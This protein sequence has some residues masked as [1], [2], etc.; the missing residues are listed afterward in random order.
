MDKNYLDFF[1]NSIAKLRTENLYRQFT[2]ISR[3]KG[4]F[5]YAINNLNNHKITLW[6]SNDY[7]A[8]GQNEKA[9]K[10]ANQA[11]S[12]FGLG[13]GGTRNIS[14]NNEL[15]VKLEKEIAELYGKPSALCFVSGYV[16]NDATI[17]TLAKIIPNLVIFSDEKNHASIISGIR[18][19]KLEKHIFRHNDTND[20]E[21]LLKQFPKESP[22]IIIFESVYSMDGDFGEIA[23]IVQLAKKYNALTYCD[24]VH[25][26]GLYGKKGSGLCEEIGLTDEID[27]I[28][29][30]LAKSYGCIGGYI[31]GEKDLIDAIRL[32]SSGFIFTTSLPPSICAAAIE[33]INHLK[34]SDIE[35]KTHHQNVL[36][37]KTALKNAGIEIV[38]NQSHIVSV[39]IG[40]AKKAQEISQK[41]LQNYDIYIQHI[42]YPTIAKGDERLR[43]TITPL[44]TEKMIEDLV[45]A[46]KKII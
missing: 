14:G 32:N 21:M 22:K 29:A 46:L 27:I 8:M 39:R 19:S 31:T 2:N 18:N 44:H 12:S 10:A 24:E 42:N 20:L 38:P 40:D 34:N 23:K 25:A 7:L 1:S 45:S 5:P 9:I 17:Q 11:N 3:I 30:T 4:E 35:R 37:L 36:K 15:I 13:S 6:C 28:Q 26:A 16:A 41:L 43:I 33:N